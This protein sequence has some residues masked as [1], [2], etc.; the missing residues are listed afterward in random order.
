M[1][2]FPAAHSSL[3]QGPRPLLWVGRSCLYRVFC[4]T[5][6]EIQM[7][8]RIRLDPSAEQ[9]TGLS[10]RPGIPGTEGSKIQGQV[11]LKLNICKGEKAGDQAVCRGWGDA[12]QIMPC[13]TFAWLAMFLALLFKEYFSEE[14]RNS[15]KMQIQPCME[16]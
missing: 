7:Q 15:R 4:N 2:T 8:G 6:P 9:A 14:R 5:F 1:S 11:L 10:Q 3:V 16:M 13:T 12:L